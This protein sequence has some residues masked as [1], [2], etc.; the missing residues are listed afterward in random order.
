[1]Q[2][3]SEKDG[4]LVNHWYILCLENEVPVEK[5]IRRWL[6]DKPYAVFR[7]QQQKIHVI[8]DRCLHRG[9]QLSLGSV[10]NGNIKCPY[11]GWS[12]DGE[13][14][15]VEVPSEGPDH[16]EKRKWCLSKVWS[17][18][19]DAC[20]WIW[21]GAEAP[22]SDLPPWRFPEF[23]NPRAQS[24][25][26]ITDFENEVGHLVQNF[27]DVP[28]TVFV[29]SGWFRNRSL[30]K[31]PVQISVKERRVKVTYNQPKDSIGF[32]EKVLNP[33]GEAMIHTDEFIFPNITRVDY[34][35]GNKFFI[36][37]SQCTPISRYQ[38]RVYTWIAYQVGPLSRVLKPFMRFY[39][40]KVITQDVEIMKNQGDNL[41]IWGESAWKST[42]ADELHLAIDRLR[43]GESLD[44]AYEKEREFW[45]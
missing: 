5:P 6:Y 35:F 11:H 23:K 34:Q 40:R 4:N 33:R 31:V 38:S 37:N 16:V 20:V 1:M 14:N 41:K 3:L 44:S 24:Y 30:L 19:Q 7:D 27:M 28:H 25:F 2:S 22:T 15:L 21:G 17:V 12:Y 8:P 36:I 39:T 45:I 29:H 42:A 43:S 10:D 9:A 32:T 13:G 18:C 26:M